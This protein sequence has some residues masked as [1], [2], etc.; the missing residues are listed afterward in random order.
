MNLVGA[1]GQGESVWLTWFLAHVLERFSD[2]CLRRG[3]SDLA[4]RYRDEARRFGKAAD[5]AWDG[6]WYLRGYYDSGKTL[7]SGEDEECQ[8]DAI[9]QGFATLTK[10]SDPRKVQLALRSAITRLFDQ[11][12]GIVRLF[13]PAFED[14]AENPGYIRGYAPGL[15]E[16]GGQYTH[17]ILWLIMGA[18]RAG[19]REEG[20]DMLKAIIPGHH[21][22]SSYRGEPY[23][24]A[25]D[26]YGNPQ[27]LGRAGWT[28]YTGASGWF[29]REA[30]ENLLGVNLREG[31]LYIEPN[32]PKDLPSYTVDWRAGDKT[33]HIRVDRGEITVNG[34]PYRGEG[35]S[36]KETLS[37]MKK[38]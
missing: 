17:G 28:W 3:E 37:E 13:D 30:M 25:A 9:A 11:K 22:Q 34:A 15:R 4:A 7:G 23:V 19:L 6:A 24:L 14:G 10:H 16:N 31:K 33:W 36:L 29:W 18:F 1:K 26:V 12:A 38:T 21:A 20:W 35:L 27:H 2:L 32:L 5:E 8:I